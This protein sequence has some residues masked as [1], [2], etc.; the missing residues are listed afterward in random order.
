MFLL[1]LVC[2]SVCLSVTTV[3]KKIVDGFVS[4]ELAGKKVS[5]MTYFVFDGT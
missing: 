3:T 4:P 5:R 2:V 1:A